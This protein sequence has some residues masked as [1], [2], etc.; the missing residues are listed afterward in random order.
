MPWTRSTA[1]SKRSSRRPRRPSLRPARPPPPPFRRHR[2]PEGDRGPEMDRGASSNS[3]ETLVPASPYR[4]V[5]RTANEQGGM[6]MSQTIQIRERWRG[7]R[8]LVRISGSILSG[9]A[10]G[11]LLRSVRGALARGMRDLTIDLAG[12]SSIDCGGIGA[13][14]LCLEDAVRHGATLRVARS[15]GPT[16]AF[17]PLAPPLN[18]LDRAGLAGPVADAISPRASRSLAG[19]K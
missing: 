13:L 5:S 14:L 11:K 18:T 6:T 12:L 9:A 8:A 1:R 19:P 7:R 2:H 16:P 4:R 15:R 17:L 3:P 10:A